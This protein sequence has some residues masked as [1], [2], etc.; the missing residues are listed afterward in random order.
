MS[1]EISSIRSQR[2]GPRRSKKPVRVLVFAPAAAHTS[3][4][5]SW[6]TTTVR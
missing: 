5:V 2:S 4:P 1:A 3:L 6:S